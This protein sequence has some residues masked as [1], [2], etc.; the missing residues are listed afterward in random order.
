MK[1]WLIRL[2]L[3]DISDVLRA[4]DAYLLIRFAMWKFNMSFEEVMKE[5]VNTK[6]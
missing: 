6:K 5:T 2:L 3:S 4:I 1:R